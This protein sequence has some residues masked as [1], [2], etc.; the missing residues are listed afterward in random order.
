M[1]NFPKPLAI[2]C[3][4]TDNFACLAQKYRSY[5]TK[6]SFSLLFIVIIQL[7]MLSVI[8]RKKNNRINSIIIILYNNLFDVETSCSTELSLPKSPTTETKKELHL[9]SNLLRTLLLSLKLKQK[10]FFTHKKEV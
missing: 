8:S 5:Y 3:V 4:T 9:I 7:L 10:Y 6:F 2:P 1:T